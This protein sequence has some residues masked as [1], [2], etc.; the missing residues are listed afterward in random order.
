[1]LDDV[2]YRQL[3]TV[4]DRRRSSWKNLLLHPAHDGCVSGRVRANGFRQLLEFVGLCLLIPYDASANT[5]IVRQR[6]CVAGRRTK[7]GLQCKLLGYG[8]LVL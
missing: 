8:R 3:T 4:V 6:A 7:A 1:L 5:T 2:L